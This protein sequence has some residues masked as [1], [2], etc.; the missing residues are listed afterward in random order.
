MKRTVILMHILCRWEGVSRLLEL[1]TLRSWLN[2]ENLGVSYCGYAEINQ[3]YSGVFLG[4]QRSPA[5][6]FLGTST[7][8][9]QITRQN[10]L[11]LI[12]EGTVGGLTTSM[13]SEK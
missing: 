1:T 8:K 3:R 2:Y 5:I 4:K 6:E 9:L 12:S 11:N 10:D 13:A 7:H